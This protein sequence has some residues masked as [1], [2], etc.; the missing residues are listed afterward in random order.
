MEQQQGRPITMVI[1]F[2]Y[3]LVHQEVAQ[4]QTTNVLCVFGLSTV[5][6]LL[7]Y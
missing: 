3:I 2:S 7:N 5:T 4:V 1:Q 6:K